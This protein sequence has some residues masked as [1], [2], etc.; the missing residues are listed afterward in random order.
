MQFYKLACHG[1]VS[2]R[3]ASKLACG[4]RAD[5]NLHET[6]FGVESLPPLQSRCA[7]PKCSAAR[8]AESASELGLSADDRSGIHLRR[9]RVISDVSTP[10]FSSR[11]AEKKWNP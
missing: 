10:P 8:R 6:L 7:S 4:Y 3:S 5:P 11:R 2:V 9:I 1:W